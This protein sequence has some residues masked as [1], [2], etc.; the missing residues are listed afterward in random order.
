MFSA[1]KPR[2]PLSELE[3]LVMEVVWQR[4]SVTADEVRAALAERHP[5]KESTVRT[6]LKRLGRK[7]VRA[8]PGGGP[9]QFYSGVDAPQNVAAKAVRQI[10]ERFCG[11]S[12]EQLL[13]GMVA[14]DVVDRNRGSR[15]ATG[16][17]KEREMELSCFASV[18]WLLCLAATAAAVI[19]VFRIKTPAARH[20]VWTVVMAGMLLT[21]LS[22]AP[23]MIRLGPAEMTGRL[24]RS[25]AGLSGTGPKDRIEGIVKLEILIALDGSVE[26]V[27]V[28]VGPPVLAAAAEEALLQW[29]Y[30]PTVLNGQNRK[31]GY[32]C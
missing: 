12:V 32:D 30:Q 8:A 24:V 16:S 27:N 18:R 14:N 23:S 29:N 31:G 13:V 1:R 17:L 22:Q 4:G 28:L 15:K 26:G 5:M 9:H 21:S 25:L 10:I 3:H 2:K 7:R 11:G 19:P 6:V 20:A